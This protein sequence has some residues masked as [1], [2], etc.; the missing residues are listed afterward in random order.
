MSDFYSLIKHENFV[1]IR[2][3]KTTNDYADTP[4]YETECIVTCDKCEKEE[5][6]IYTYFGGILDVYFGDDIYV[7]CKI[8]K[9]M[10]CDKCSINSDCD[11]SKIHEYYKKHL[12]RKSVDELCENCYN[13][14]YHLQEWIDYIDMNN[15]FS[16]TN[17]NNS[18]F[19]MCKGVKQ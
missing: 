3:I 15:L 11:N 18:A 19:Q 5:K 1:G 14:K 2:E 8:C 9:C 13:K 6:F 7:S 17:D 16:K 10:Y 4:K 12:F